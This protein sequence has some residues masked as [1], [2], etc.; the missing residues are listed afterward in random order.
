[1][2]N[3]K[4][5]IEYDGTDFCGWQVQPNG[6]AVQQCIEEALFAVTG[7]ETAVIGSGRTDAGVHAR[8]Q[9]ANFFTESK[10]PPQRFAQALNAY[11]P[12]SVRIKASEEAAPEFHARFSAKKK[13]YSYRIRNSAVA[14][15]L[16]GRFE[17]QCFGSLDTEKMKRVCALLEGTH[18]F[19]PFMAAG[20][21]VK[22]TVRTV[23][24]ARL[25]TDELPVLV[26]EVCGNGFLYKMV[27]NMV[28][29]LLEV[30][31]G[32]LTEKDAAEVLSGKDSFTW[33]TAPAKGLILE[34]VEYDRQEAAF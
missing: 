20:S 8:G 19:A 32:K 13:T 6:R 3:I 14:S 27:R 22:D 18:D 9:V 21:S 10:L 1:M 31:R 24:F 4:L 7:K 2:K 34:C 12:E 25:M 33:F 29:L 11:L 16:N 28:G 5:L 26:F 17:Y 30:G 23:Y 15:P